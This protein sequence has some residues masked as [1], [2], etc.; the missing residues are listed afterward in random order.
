MIL[1]W[2]RLRRD[3]VT[4]VSGAW[5][6]FTGFLLLMLLA[7]LDVSSKCGGKRLK[8]AASS[9]R[10][11]KFTRLHLPKTLAWVVF[12]STS[13]SFVLCPFVWAANDGTLSCAI[14]FSHTTHSSHT[15]FT[16]RVSSVSL[17]KIV[18]DQPV[19]CL[20][21]DYASFMFFYLT[22]FY[23]QNQSNINCSMWLYFEV[24]EMAEIFLNKLQEKLGS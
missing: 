7:R 19:C 8:V 16:P 10:C 22:H 18:S 12:I 3:D 20:T 23:T 4:G 21:L 5:E 1:L 24:P 9:G 11:L 15:L 2:F 13:G 6:S 17:E 14:H